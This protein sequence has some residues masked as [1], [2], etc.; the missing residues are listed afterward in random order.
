MNW[1]RKNTFGFRIEFEYSLIGYKYFLDENETN[2][3]K[4][5]TER[6][7]SMLVFTKYREPERIIFDRFSFGIGPKLIRRTHLYDDIISV[8][9][10]IFDIQSY[11]ALIP[12][13]IRFSFGK[14]WNITSYFSLG[15]ELGI[16]GGPA[17]KLRSNF[18]L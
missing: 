1:T 5:S 10:G 9:K 14:D 15:Y 6:F 2:L 18:N 16:G 12:I 11:G 13:A 7:H 8:P 17:I 4:R 3:Y